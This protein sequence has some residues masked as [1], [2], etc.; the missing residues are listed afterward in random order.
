MRFLVL[1]GVDVTKD[2]GD[3][4]MEKAEAGLHGAAAGSRGFNVDR[5]LSLDYD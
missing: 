3:V 1:S 4:V 5:I 2:V